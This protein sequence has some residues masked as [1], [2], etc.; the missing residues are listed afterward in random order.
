M[1]QHS[2]FA[3]SVA[4][5][6]VGTCPHMTVEVD[7]TQNP[8]TNTEQM[9]RKH[10]VCILVITQGVHVAGSNSIPGRVKLK[11]FKINT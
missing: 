1:E 8:K 5:L 7:R 11:T 4:L 2:K 3:M 10:P 9:P 6:Q